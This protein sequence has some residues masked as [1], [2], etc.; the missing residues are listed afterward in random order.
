MREL[1]ARRIQMAVGDQAVFPQPLNAMKR[2]STKAER[3]AN[4]MAF[5]TLHSIPLEQINSYDEDA[6][7]H[8]HSTDAESE[9]PATPEPILF[10]PAWIAPYSNV[11]VIVAGLENTTDH[12]RLVEAA[13]IL[14]GCPAYHVNYA[15]V[16]GMNKRTYAAKLQ[17]YLRATSKKIRSSGML[18]AVT[19]KRGTSI[20]YDPVNIPRCLQFYSGNI[21]VPLYSNPE[22]IFYRFSRSRLYRRN[23]TIRLKIKDMQFLADN[24]LEESKLKEFKFQRYE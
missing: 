14:T 19:C 21:I 22:H 2:E 17:K 12:I 23:L 9:E 8:E 18:L 11:L 10:Q 15:A 16:P 1:I 20:D 4:R 6:L 3:M 5:I 7:L 24:A 13:H